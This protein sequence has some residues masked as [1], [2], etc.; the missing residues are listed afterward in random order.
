MINQNQPDISNRLDQFLDGIL[1]IFIKNPVKGEVKSRLA[2]TLGEEK[3]L[4]IYLQ[5][6]LHTRIVSQAVNVRRWLYYSAYVDTEDDWP[7]GHFEKKLQAKGNLGFKMESAF[8]EAF[9]QSPKVVIIGSDCPEIDSGVIQSAFEELDDY[10]F[11]IG[12]ATDGGYY[13]LGMRE[14][15]PSLFRNKPWSTSKILDETLETIQPL[16]KVFLLPELS[17]L[18]TE[19][20]LKR[21]DWEPS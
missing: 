21:M 13:L 2:E 12:P 7:K 3:A 4:N 20:D 9:L 5:L 11:V 16:G 10:P 14:F 17:D 18:D 8:R 15:Q 6:L 1:I 19:E